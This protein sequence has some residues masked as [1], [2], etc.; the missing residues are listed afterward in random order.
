MRKVWT[1]SLV[2]AAAVG[3]LAVVASAAGTTPIRGGPETSLP[4]VPPTTV[5]SRYVVVGDG[6]VLRVGNTVYV[7][8][9]SRLGVPTGSAIVLS[10]QT[11]TAQPIM[12]RVSG[13]SVQAV[14]PDGAGGWYVGGTF[15]SVGGVGRPGLAHLLTDGT[16][17]TAFAPPG[18]GQVRALALDAGRLYVGGIQPLSADPWFLPVL[19][20]LDPATGALLPVSYQLLPHTDQSPAFGVIA[21]A[22]ADGRL[23]AAFNGDNGIAAYDEGSG[24]LLWSQPGTPSYGEYSGP[25]AIGL[26]G[27]RLLVGG[28]LSAP[29]GPVDFEELDPATG[30]L[31]AQPA[32]DGPVAGMATGS[33]NAYLLVRSPHIFG[34]SVWKLGISSGTL[35]RLVVVRGASAVAVNSPNLYVAGQAAVRG[36]VRVYAF[37]T[38][39]ATPS[40]RALPP[41]LVGGGVGA[42]AVQSGHLLVG[43]SFLGTGGV[44]RNGLAAFDARTGSLL[45]WRPAVPTGRVAALA[46]SG[47]KIY[48]AGAFKRVAGRPRVGLAAV[49]ARGRGRLLPW[50]PR[51]SQGSF[52]SLVVSQGR[53][54]AGGS[55]KPRGAKSS[56]PFRHLLVF[57]AR[58]GRRLP[59]KSR[60]GHVNLM[61]LGHGL[62]IAE[63][64]CDEDGSTAACITA[65]R[66]GGIGRPV[67]RQSIPGRVSALATRTF[68]LYVGG[69]FSS[70]DGQARTNLAAFALDETGKL[71]DF[72]PR[73]SLPVTSLAPTGYGL[74]YA[75]NAFGSD[76]SGPHFVGAQAL[77]AVAAD[78]TELPW[79]MTFPPN[80]VPV[81]PSDTAALAGNFAVGHLT[82]VAGGL[83]ARGDFSWIGPADNPAPGNLVWLR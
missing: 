70:V 36:D 9:V 59:F 55:A 64:S 6:P 54:F 47:K 72:A 21:L 43:G 58:T 40:P 33:T 78:G 76:S 27:G 57:S 11:G 38:R 41:V 71:L 32:I 52:G 3:G 10:T 28:E 24:A 45:P 12:A 53:V 8:G 56:T 83:V 80:D 65:F 79:Q 29:D 18:L 19:S 60:I 34:L 66:V 73:L 23:F 16:L 77:G 50:H 49:S 37:D 2:L 81:S 1:S 46:S 67:W 13:G 82:P 48:L 5:S 7:G 30:S 42:L 14:I 68:T 62:V 22:A 39:Q 35:T 31:V 75:A 74:V 61:A 26:A 17:D 25:A 63:N 4:A 69:Q 44:K 51:L 15:T 20:A